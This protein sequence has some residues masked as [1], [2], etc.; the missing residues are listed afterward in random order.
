MNPHIS[1]TASS[2][3]G[4]R[5]SWFRWGKKTG[6]LQL[7]SH[8]ESPQTPVHLS[9]TPSRGPSRPPSFMNV[10]PGS[11]AGSIAPLMRDMEETQENLEHNKQLVDQMSYR[12]L[13]R[14]K[15][16]AGFEGQ[17]TELKAK[18]V[19]LEA[20]VAT[21]KEAHAACKEGRVENEIHLASYIS[22]LEMEIK[23]QHV[24][25]D[26]LKQKL[27]SNELKIATKTSVIQELEGKRDKAQAQLAA[28]RSINHNQVNKFSK[29]SKITSSVQEQFEVI[30]KEI[31]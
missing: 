13:A 9:I 1:A 28:E 25:I 10:R 26:E 30:Y 15:E 16:I 29:A 19:D 3:S 12:L 4:K 23:S 14:D 11:M 7:T 31:V 21:E 22:E 27:A 5:S 6:F 8:P 17:V 18:S 2:S 20:Q 24:A